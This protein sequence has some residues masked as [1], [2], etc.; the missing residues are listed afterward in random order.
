MNS[1]LKTENTSAE[2][3]GALKSGV[4]LVDRSA[5][6]RLAV[7]GK[8]ALDLLSR[9][10]TNAL[11]DLAPGR[12][13]QTVLTSN[14]GR[15]VDVL[16]VL[17]QDDRLL[18]LT[19]PATRQKVAEWMDFYTF[20]EDVAVKDVTLDTAM[21]SLSGP[22]A[23]EVLDAMSCMSASA[24]APYEHVYTGLGDVE[25]MV[26]RT[27]FTGLPGFDI[28][29]PAA[30]AEALRNTLLSAGE[31]LGIAAAT[32]EA[33]EIV[34]IERGVPAYGKELGEDYN[35]LE[36]GLIGLVS[37]TKGCYIGQEVV[38]RLN[39]YQKVQKQLVALRWD[40]AADVQAGAPLM[41]DGKK[42]GVV[43]SAAR[44][45]GSGTGIGLGYVRKAQAEAGTKLEGPGG[46][47]VEVIS[48]FRQ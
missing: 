16:T 39:T 6:G 46:A 33:V 5:L 34:R 44:L 23:G 26:A 19:S 13:M 20:T 37:F 45:P 24:L 40:G 8:D 9:L 4:A 35:P 21:L 1:E 38:T 48:S 11:L 47:A 42:A 3:H 15:I 25:A 32:Q 27:D 31:P 29:A 14:K 17:R 18:V 41:M 30:H 7:K 43:T 36:A 10:S 2:Q 12:G 22:R 28:I